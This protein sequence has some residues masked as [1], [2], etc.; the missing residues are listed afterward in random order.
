MKRAL[1]LLIAILTSSLAFA[2]VEDGKTLFEQKCDKCHSLER[3]LKKTKDLA[4]WKKTNL[5]MMKKSRGDITEQDV[6]KISDYL[7][8][9][10]K[11][12]KPAVEAKPEKE[13]KMVEK[14]DLFDFKKVRVDQFIDPAVCGDCH[15]EKFQ[16]WNG[17]MHSKAFADPLWRAATKL[18]F[19]ESVKEEALLEMKACIK[20]HTPL[21]FRSH[22]IS[23]P[24]DDFDKLA[25]LPAQGIFCN[26]CHNINE[27]KHIGNDGYEVAPGGG[28][29]DPST[30]LGPLKDAYSDFHP[31]KYSEL[32]TRAEFCGLCHNV[33]HAANNL[34]LE[35]TYNEWKNSPYNTKNP[36]TT[37]N[38]QDCHMRQRPGIPATG[39]T[40]RPDNPGKAADDGPDRKHIWT[41]YFVGA[42][43]LITKLL[44][45]EIHAQM[46][47]ERLKNAADL[48]LIKSESYTQNG[49]SHISVKVTNSG[50]GHY[51]PTGLTEVR[52][53]WLDVTITDSAGKTIFR[54]G[55]LDT[56]GNLDEHAVLYYTLLGNEKGAPVVNVAMADRILYDHRIPPKGY[57]IEKYSFQI[58]SEAVSPLTVAATLKYRS[59]SQSLARKLLGNSAPE[60][61]VVDMVGVVD[62]LEF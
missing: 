26:W 57:L 39:K 42:N 24:K 3:S 41:H 34:P 21:G 61:T 22:S 59:A 33:S 46:A 17:S 1:I 4:A 48:E 25:E 44:N 62:K 35:Q 6:E 11:P 36:A 31:T 50:A 19:K 2:T 51:L 16:Q 18:F 13:A 38:C 32:H 9:R 23:S 15:S 20:C 58:P 8:G 40:P 52:Q 12:V 5:R 7:A 27:V 54:S 14:H 10:G 30:M 43:A 45:S 29:E 55:A 60:I 56:N 49:L 53:M 47:V 28:E 37:V